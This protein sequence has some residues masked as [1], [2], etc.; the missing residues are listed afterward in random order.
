MGRRNFNDG[1][2][3]LL[4]DLNAITY[5]IE[6]Q[7]YERLLPYL[8][9][10]LDDAFFEG[11]FLVSRTDAD[12]VSIAA[13]LGF[14]R[15]NSLLSPATRLMPIY[16]SGAQPINIDAA[17]PTDPR[18]D[19]ICVKS[20]VTDELTESRNFKD[21]DDSSVTP[22]DMVIQKDWASDVVYVA[23][24]ADP[25][26]SAPATPAGY[27]KIATITVTAVTGIAADSDV[28]DNRKSIHMRKPLELRTAA[29]AYAPGK[30]MSRSI[31]FDATLGNQSLT[32]PT[33]ISGVDD[34]L[35]F[36]GKKI[37]ASANTV[38]FTGTVEGEVNPVIEN[39]YTGRTVIAYGGVWYWK[40]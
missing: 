30:A 6:R 40:E 16:S 38:T 25:S 37:D 9:A 33:I 1:Q 36:T 35:E 7:I 14:Q 24:T 34:G 39:R 17:D 10:N 20:D 19:I 12:T 26:P 4:E 5:A 32:L 29:G 13:G 11:S 23:G 8:N 28:T 22:Q 15:D 2:E 27:I 21:A 3:V 31:Y 18:I